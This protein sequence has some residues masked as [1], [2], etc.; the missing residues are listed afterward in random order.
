MDP[1]SQ[2]RSPWWRQ[3]KPGAWL[4]LLVLAFLLGLAL[5]FLANGWSSAG[6]AATEISA[7][8]YVAMA[9]GVLATLALGIGLMALMFYSNR[10][11]R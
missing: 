9:L 3:Q 10:I 6:D 4:L 1:G 2:K 5:V 11:G 7:M 8:G